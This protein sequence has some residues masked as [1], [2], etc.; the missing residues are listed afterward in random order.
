[1]RIEFR[2]AAMNNGSFLDFI[3]GD[4]ATSSILTVPA[5][6]SPAELD[7]RIAAGGT[8]PGTGITGP[9]TVA[10]LTP[11][12]ANQ[13]AVSYS[14]A[15][16]SA[17]HTPV[18]VSNTE[19][20]GAAP[21]GAKFG[22]D[23]AA[24][25]LYYVN[26]AGDWAIYESDATGAIIT[27]STPFV[28]AVGNANNL[29]AIDEAT[30]VIYYRDGAGN[31]QP[32]STS[33]WRPISDSTVTLAT[34][35]NYRV[36]ALTAPKT[37]TSHNIAND[38]SVRIAD[39][40]SLTVAHDLTLDL[41]GTIYYTD[42]NTGVAASASMPFILDIA[43]GDA[44]LIRRGTDWDL[45]SHTA[46]GRETTEPI[47]YYSAGD[48]LDARPHYAILTTPGE[49]EMPMQ[50]QG[51]RVKFLALTDDITLRAIGTGNAAE[52]E[53]DGQKSDDQLLSIITREWATAI[54]RT[55][56]PWYVRHGELDHA[57]E[58]NRPITAL[59]TESYDSQTS[60]LAFTSS[61]APA[62]GE[63]LTL[64][65]FTGVISDPGQA[66]DG[67][68]LVVEW[69]DHNDATP[70]VSDTGGTPTVR[71]AAGQITGSGGSWSF[72][73]DDNN[74]FRVSS[75]GTLT[76]TIYV[77]DSAGNNTSWEIQ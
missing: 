48:A 5:M 22:V 36:T 70:A 75:A 34:G 21:S 77:E 43:G 11:A 37:I 31:W 56:G 71:V 58:V 26:A 44:T 17:L 8:T 7:R 65:R 57:V 72:V 32:A 4:Q 23:I 55:G 16:N 13:I 38:H 66:N 49:Y 28:G 69:A 1:M 53:F 47:K 63:D 18:V 59:G 20:T 74:D 24:P 27:G 41:G 73:V 35:G 61:S 33:L 50:E 46:G 40:S 42:P 10:N 12:L 51:L 62:I 29:L 19:L 64:V 2:R 6:W 60:I 54:G 14:H 67:R 25:A 15:Q 52:W 39:P 30:G 76:T 68:T 3:I 9:I 45:I